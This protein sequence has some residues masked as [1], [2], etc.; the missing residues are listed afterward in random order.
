MRWARISHVLSL[1]RLPLDQDLFTAFTHHVV[2]V[3]DVEDENL[4]EHFPAC[5][6]FIQHGLDAGGGVLVHW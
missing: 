3:D 1:L 5:N 2:E 4:I 6:T